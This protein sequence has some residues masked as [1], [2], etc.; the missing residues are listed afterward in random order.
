M[1]RVIVN[2]VVLQMTCGNDFMAQDANAI[3]RDAIHGL[4]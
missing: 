3:Q 2:I 4:D 1:P